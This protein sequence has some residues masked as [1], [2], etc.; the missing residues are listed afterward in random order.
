MFGSLALL[1]LTGSRLI[2]S[3]RLREATVSG[4]LSG[5]KALVIGDS[6]HLNRLHCDYLL[7]RFGIREIGRFGISE[8]GGDLNDDTVT[9]DAVIRR[10]QETTTDQILLAVRWNDN[11]RI[12]RILQKLR[13][14]PV[15]VFLLLTNLLTLF[16]G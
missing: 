13:V 15:P 7:R 6:E 4:R 1:L 11:R 12:G 9:L 14:L 8:A 3:G 16:F 5:P 2:I 10:A